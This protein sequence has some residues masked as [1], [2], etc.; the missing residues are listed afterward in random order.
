MANDQKLE[1]L[2]KALLSKSAE[3]PWLIPSIVNPALQKEVILYMLKNWSLHNSKEK[4]AIFFLILCVKKST[5]TALQ[6]LLS[7][8]LLAGA[9]DLDDCWV[10]V[11]SKMMINYP[12][13]GELDLTVENYL[14][15]E[16]QQQFNYIRLIKVDIV[17]S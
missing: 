17:N 14:P 10:C 1:N 13:T 11:F 16:I 2:A 6:E 3:N 15:R 5:V 7:E 9:S 12:K 8:I 4:L